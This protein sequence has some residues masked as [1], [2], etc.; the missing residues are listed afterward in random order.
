MYRLFKNFIRPLPVSPDGH[1]VS[2]GYHRPY[3]AATLLTSHK[4]QQSLKILWDNATLPQETYQLYFMLPLERSIDLIQQFPFAPTGHYS[5][6]GGM[7]EVMLIT[8]TRAVRLSKGYMFPLGASPET[9]AAQSDIWT[10]VV[11]YAALLSSLKPLFRMKVELQN[12]HIWSPLDGPLKEPYR[13][14]FI[15]DT[16][17]INIQILNS[18]LACR[19]LPQEGIAWLK[20]CPDALETLGHYLFGFTNE[21]EIINSI[22]EEAFP[23]VL[24]FQK[25]TVISNID[26]I[27]LQKQPLQ[28]ER[29]TSDIE[30]FSHVSNNL[31][32][33]FW[34][35]LKE[36]CSSG[37]L[38]VNAT[39]SYIHYVAGFIF[40]CA[41]GI[42]H[43]F[44]AEQ[45]LPASQKTVL[46]R[47]F[48][49][50]G[51]HR[52]N[53]GRMHIGHLYNDEK[54]EG[55]YKKLN[56]YLIV[57]KEIYEKSHTKKDNS[58]LIIL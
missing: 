36:G 29:I 27:A 55:K 15:D 25:A 31:G 42:F 21:S 38:A 7:A 24:T 52:Q 33:A 30:H 11:F 8:L 54:K 45:G 50:L 18:I 58:A 19:L 10:G 35:W 56:G 13:Y 1:T 46:Q 6:T 39:D 5:D 43:Q 3:D 4:Y 53:R 16:S 26:D 14:R 22:I 37:C 57:N 23:E 49:K 41:P 2:P 12:G 32:H 40:I 17:Q 9:Q 47:E 44:L 34:M 20:S 28:K 51:Y 48:E